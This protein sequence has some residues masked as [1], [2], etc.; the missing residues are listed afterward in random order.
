[1]SWTAFD[2]ARP[3]CRRPRSLGLTFRSQLRSF[4]PRGACMYTSAAAG[5][6]TARS[7]ANTTLESTLIL[8]LCRNQEARGQGHAGLGWMLAGGGG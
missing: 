6:Q 1:M 5:V 2:A 8:R 4:D 7:V 3:S